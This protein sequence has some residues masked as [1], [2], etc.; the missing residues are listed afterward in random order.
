VE[1]VVRVVVLGSG[2]RE[3]AIAWRAEQDGADVVVAPGNAGI[4]EDV[5]TAALNLSDPEQVLELVGRESPDLVVVGPEQPLVDGIA[6]RLRGAGHLVFGPSA[7][8]ARLEGSKV[9]AKAFMREFGIPTARAVIVRELEAGLKAIREFEVPPVVK[10]SGL[11]AGKGVV[12]SE[13]YAEAELA[14]RACLLDNKFGSAGHEIV[15]EERLEGDEVSFFVI[16]D[17]ERI[18]RFESAQDHKRLGD[19]DAGPNTGGMGAI[20]PTPICSSSVTAAVLERIV[21]P[22]LAGLRAQGRPFQ[23]VLFVGLMIDSSGEPR[24]IEYNVRFGDPEIQPIL[25]GA[26]DPVL[27]QL[28]AAA[29]GRLDPGHISGSPAATIVAASAGYPESSTRGAAIGGLAEIRALAD[30]KVFHAATRRDPDGTWRSDGGRVLGVCARGDTLPQA[31]DRVY[32]A[33]SHLTMEGMQIR[34]DIGAMWRV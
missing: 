28:L 31:L 24:V 7:A 8:A 14:V 6:D 20:T 23:G 25:F 2:A 29:Q 34:R 12:V 3:H 26:V 21:T 10:A 32:A 13:S 5:R 1:E 15:L 30:T 4:G 22:T 9:E 16:T 18:C 11:A 33:A 27:P 17:G 19:G